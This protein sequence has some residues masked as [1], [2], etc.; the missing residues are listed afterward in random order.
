MKKPTPK[1]Q[2]LLAKLLEQKGVS[3]DDLLPRD[4][5]GNLPT[6]TR[7]SISALISTLTSMEDKGGWT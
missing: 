2:Q 5:G 4:I 1:Q 6:P 7:S 3:L